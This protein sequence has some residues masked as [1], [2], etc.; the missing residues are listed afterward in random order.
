MPGKTRRHEDKE[1]KLRKKLDIFRK[2]NDSLFLR[3]YKL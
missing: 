2:N 1:A 3:F